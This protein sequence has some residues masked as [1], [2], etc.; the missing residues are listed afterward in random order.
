MGNKIWIQDYM[1]YGCVV[2]IAPTE[3]KAREIMSES[4]M[5]Y[6]ANARVISRGFEEGLVWENL[7]DR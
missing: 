2:V 4:S 1:Y 3:E 7:G 5:N 6:D